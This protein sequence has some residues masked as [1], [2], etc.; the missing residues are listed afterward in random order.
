MD[1]KSSAFQSIRSKGELDF[2][3][4]I[5]FLWIN[6]I[7]VVKITIIFFLLGIFIAFGSR[8]EY[9]AEAKLLPEPHGKEVGSSSLL[10]QFGNLGNLA[11]IDLSSIGGQDA[12]RPELYPE[13]IQSTPFLVHLMNEKVFVPGIDSAVSIGYYLN[14]LAYVSVIDY[15]KKYTIGLPG[16]IVFFVKKNHR[17]TPLKGD[18]TSINLTFEEYGVIKKMK[19]RLWAEINE[20]NGIISIVAKFPDP[21]IAAKVADES[22]KS[23]TEYVTDYRLGKARNTLEFTQRQTEE[24]RNEFEKAQNNLAFFRDANKNIISSKLKSEED[25]L[26]AQYNLAFNLYNGL[27]QQLEQSKINVQ[28]ETPIFKVLNPVQIPY[29]RSSPKRSLILVLSIFLGIFI[30]STLVLI[31]AW[32]ASPSS[33][34]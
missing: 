6:K 12:V 14:D 15:I 23:L 10:S 34:L 26:Q 13:I 7:S 27:S 28:Q 22:T 25:R 9:K 11:G 33:N 4:V 29:E 19:K 30:G 5:R 3:A 24:A 1:L 20:N 18:R 21:L 16:K 32:A 31:K 8:K 17:I 2:I